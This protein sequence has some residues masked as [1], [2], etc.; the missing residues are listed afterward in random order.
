MNEERNEISVSLRDLVG[1]VLR[2]AVVAGILAVLAGG[3]TFF[4]GQRQDPVYR[5]EA[6]LLVVRGT[7]GFTQLGLTPVTAPPIDLG[8]YQV[9]A[10]S[11]RVL[12]DALQLMG[13]EAPN[14][15]EI[16]ALRRSVGSTVDAGVRDSS[17]LRIDARA[18]TPEV[19]VRRANAVAMALVTWDRAR[20]S[21]TMTR[22]IATLE[23]QIEALSEQ[24]RS[25]QVI[26]D[27]AS[28]TQVDGLVRLR[29]EQQQQLAYARALIASA[30][31]LVS[32]MQTAE[33]TVRQV[34]PRPAMN[35]II[36]ALLA[37]ALTYVVL[38]LRAAFDT[39]MRSADDIAAATGAPVIAEFPVARG[40]NEG[41][42]REASSYLRAKLLFATAEAHPR[43][44]MVTSA[45]DAE[46][47]TTV[48]LHL[49]E[50]FVRYGY[51]T[52]LVDADLRSPSLLEHYQVMGSTGDVTP[53]R[54][55]L[56]DPEG[57][58]RVLRIKM[59]GEGV[60]DLVP[61]FDR[62]EDAPEALG[63][64][65]WRLLERWA[66]YDVVVIDTAPVLAVADPLIIAPLCTGTV[67]VVD[68]N[69]TD[70]PSAVA[71]AQMLRGVGSQLLGV[72]PNQVATSRKRFAYGAGYGSETKKGP[73]PAR[74]DKEIARPAPLP[75]V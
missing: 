50:G 54:G 43:V 33:T 52:L 34:A 39:R 44:F 14:A 27:A 66:H 25:L 22:V 24:V 8:A 56:Q 2:G 62:T 4:L 63:R 26:G 30:E 1:F 55:W 64:G 7:A 61:Q 31:G 13:V 47:K 67:L 35:A 32:M 10:T 21:D 16:R 18:P 58:H 9:A 29:A 73:V 68:P 60:L 38:L 71:A 45:Q 37:I 57:R 20:A 36:A 74:R 49:A 12:V 69:R 59:V 53:L 6:T 41:R 70:R 5:A 11:D 19:S 48:A 75:D 72:V 17:L 46:G 51:R 65:F 15:G 23:Q 3:V 28:Q 42:L 40:R